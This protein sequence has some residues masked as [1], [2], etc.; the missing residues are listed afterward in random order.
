MGKHISDS[1]H[2]PCCHIVNSDDDQP[3]IMEI[4]AG[5]DRSGQL[6][7][8]VDY[9]DYEEPE[10]NCST[11]AIVDLEDS[12]KMA[13]RH[14]VKHDELPEFIRDSMEDWRDIVNPTFTQVKDCFKEITECLLDE[15]CRFTI[16]RTTGKY[17]M[18]L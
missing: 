18:E 15:G 8:C 17:S 10:C 4:V 16:E 6:V 14:H 13:G 12:R 3:M 2:E 5:F 1:L 9:T 7:V 11:A